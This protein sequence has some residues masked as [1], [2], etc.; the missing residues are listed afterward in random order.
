ME[1]QLS[2]R[3]FLLGV[4]L[5]AISGC[6]TA[7]RMED[8]ERRIGH[9]ED[10]N[11]MKGTEDVGARNMWWRNGLTGGGDA[12][13]GISHTVLATGDGVIV[14]A[15]DGSSP[16]AYIFNYDPSATNS[17]DSP[18]LIAPTSGGGGWR[19]TDIYSQTYNTSAG[20]GSRYIDVSNTSTPTGVDGRCFYNKTTNKWCCYNGADWECA[21]LAE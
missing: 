11:I 10:D 15:T 18:R 20:D 4:P 21:S 1:R 17:N 6:V 5:L 16:N 13:D 14:I 8:I 9:L 19:L 12:L 3:A 2:R 7:Q